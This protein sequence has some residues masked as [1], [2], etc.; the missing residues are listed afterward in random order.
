MLGFAGEWPAKSADGK[1]RLLALFR[2]RER[3]DALGQ[4]RD[5]SRAGILV[6]DALGDGAHR[7]RLCL[8]QLSLSL[9]RVARS[10]R[11]FHAAP[12]RPH[13]R[14]ARLIDRRAAADDAVGFLCGLRIRH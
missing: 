6:H 2:T 13:A 7:R 12:R 4:T 1:A 14:T 11:F 8:T 3:A 5:F 10:N 9:L